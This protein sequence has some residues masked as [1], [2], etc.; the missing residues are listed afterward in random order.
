[1][2]CSICPAASRSSPA[3]MAASGSAW[4]RGWRRRVRRW[5]WPG[6]TPAKGA[7][8]VKQIKDAGGKAEFAEVDVLSETS[9]RA[10]IDGVAKT[11]RQA[12]HP[13]QQRGHEHPQGAGHPQAR[14][15]AHRDGHQSHQR[16]HLHARGLPAHEEGGRRQ[17]HQHR[18]DDVDLLGAVL[19]GLLRRARAASCSSR[20]RARPRGRRTTSRSIRSCRAGSTPN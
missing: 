15:M 2:A 11:A 16:I 19:A 9:C 12:Q 14:G 13:R 20:A 1:M 6:A 3:A 18:L 17:D 8:A 10:L 4:P 7:A 5:C